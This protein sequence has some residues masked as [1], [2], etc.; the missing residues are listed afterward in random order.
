MACHIAASIVKSLSV[1]VSLIAQFGKD[2]LPCHKD[3]QEACGEV[4]M[5]HGQVEVSGQQ[6]AR[7]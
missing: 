5:P 6:S 4:H 7:N 1:S 3:T 2:Q